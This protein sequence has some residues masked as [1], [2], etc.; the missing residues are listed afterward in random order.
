MGYFDDTDIVLAFQSSRM[1]PD[2]SIKPTFPIFISD[3]IRNGKDLTTNLVVRESSS[4]VASAKKFLKYVRSSEYTATNSLEAY[5]SSFAVDSS[6]YSSHMEDI[7][8][9]PVNI[10]EITLGYMIDEF[11]V[12][13]YLADTYEYDETTNEMTVASG[14]YTRTVTY[15]SFIY[16]A[17]EF[18]VTVTDITEPPDEEFTPITELDPF[19]KTY[20]TNFYY[21]V[22]YLA[23]D[24]GITKFWSEV[25]PTY[26]NDIPNPYLD[27]SLSSGYF[28]KIPLRENGVSVTLENRPDD[29]PSIKKA[30]DIFNLNVDELVKIVEDIPNQEGSEIRLDEITDAYFS[31]GIG[32]FSDTQVT[33]EYAFKFF[34]NFLYNGRQRIRFTDLVKDTYIDASSI[35]TSIITRAYP[36]GSYQVEY[37]GI[38]NETCGYDSEGVY[39]C[40]TDGNNRITNI[41]LIH[42]ISTNQAE[43]IQVT[44]VIFC[45][46]SY[47]GI[48]ISEPS[49]SIKSGTDELLYKSDT[50]E[51]IKYLG[52]LPLSLDIISQCKL[53]TRDM[54]I[55][56]SMRLEINI[57]KTITISKTFFDTFFGQALLFIMGMNGLEETA[58]A[59]FWAA[60]EQG[61]SWEA[62]NLAAAYAVAGQL[63]TQEVLKLGL[64]RVLALSN[65]KYVKG[66]AILTYAYLSGLSS[67]T[68][69][70]SMLSFNSLAKMTNAVL[71]G[72]SMDLGMQ[73]QEIQ[74]QTSEIM[75]KNAEEL[76]KIKKLQE[77]LD[78]HNMGGEYL[79]QMTKV[80]LIFPDEKPEEFFRRTSLIG[81]EVITE[82]FN[83][84][85]N[86]YSSNLNLDNIRV[87]AYSGSAILIK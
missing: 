80:N 78:A 3:I 69:D 45:K 53:S 32:T 44:D 79:T 77:E 55:R 23:L 54:L 6:A 56:S 74:D 41:T 2:S 40:G 22:R 87:P 50:P 68:E 24:D 85:A 36:V 72:M 17:G 30:L 5:I 75:K 9:Y 57:N 46:E 8:G 67:K 82:Y 12:K 51:D 84:F 81:S 16:T 27:T 7:L 39:S 31:M 48:N 29:Y 19:D 33:N 1:Y 63:I 61:A 70:S 43:S 66:G 60:A 28:P 4:T 15:T 73:I 76:D 83:G 65:N 71:T 13:K 11:F 42:Q 49:G 52:I 35:T 38:A 64:G 47:S 58:D 62:A 59:A 20:S 18:T 21:Q 10:T 37:V 34:R 26:N 25:L 86:Y 14:G